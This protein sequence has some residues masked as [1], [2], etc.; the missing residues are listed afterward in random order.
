[1]TDDYEPLLEATVEIAA[2]AAKVWAL[3]GDVRRMPLWSPQVLSTRLRDGY[4]A[5]SVGTEF[6][7]L[8]HERD[9]LQWTTHAR[10]VRLTPERELAFQIEENR[11][12]WAFQLTPTDANHTRL[13]QRRETP[14]GI[15][16]ASLELTDRFLGGQ[17]K[18]TVTLRSGMR[19]T[20][21]RIKASAECQA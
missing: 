18:F 13:T 15:S 9:E 3:I 2:P 8:N 4:D 12:I 19:Q 7:N 20:L 17:E 16:Q 21:Q 10:I 5:L 6:T 11:V 14:D 1:V